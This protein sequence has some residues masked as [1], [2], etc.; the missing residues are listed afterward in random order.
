MFLFKTGA[1][2]KKRSQDTRNSRLGRRNE[3]AETESGKSS[4]NIRLNCLCSALSEYGQ[5]I[6]KILKNVNNDH[7]L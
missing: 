1:K 7:I 2:C 4:L 6:T 3:K 5:K